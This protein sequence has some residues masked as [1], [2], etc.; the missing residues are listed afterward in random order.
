MRIGDVLYFS[1]RYRFEDLN[2]D[3]A[4]TTV[5]ALHDRLIGF[6]LAPA[7]RLAEVNDAFAAGLLCCAAIDFIALCA[8]DEPQVWLAKNIEAF[9]DETLANQFWIRFRHGLMHEGR[10]KAFG[11]FS[12]DL[13]ALATVQGPAL[14]IN[15]RRLQQATQDALTAYLEKLDGA[16]T[17]RVLK[18]LR[19]YFQ[20]E[21]DV[22]VK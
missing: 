12:L 13:P 11:E 22:A 7:S 14:I 16:D 15:P 19:R 10:V 17:E 3:D 5:A 4:P 21:I 1:P 2:F 9:S 18:R 20:A 8:G 6:Y